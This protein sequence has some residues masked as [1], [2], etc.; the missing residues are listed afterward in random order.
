VQSTLLIAAHPDDEVIGAGARLA[1]FPNLTIAHITDGAPRNMY[2]AARH[3]FQSPA[4]Y[5]K[6]RRNELLR[7][8]AALSADHARTV[9]LGV[10]DQD[11]AY[12]LAELTEAIAGLI[13]DVAPDIILTHPYEGG[14]PDHD[15]CAFAVHAATK[16]R[17]GAPGAGQGT[18]PTLFEFACYHAGA[19]GI[20]TGEF[21]D[22]LGEVT[23]L[24]LSQTELERKD[25][26]LACFETQR[27]TLSLLRSTRECFRPAP[28]YDFTRP[29]HPGK[30]YY[31]QFDWGVTGAAFR[32]LAA[33]AARELDIH[34]EKF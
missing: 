1:A 18:R 9:E 15:A 4:E 2:D 13:R 33:R 30:L 5:A 21:L 16:S 27:E 20:Q 19:N 8:L 14:H 23:T 34:A 6:A 10:P 32:D 17:A 11:A 28:L 26:A 24:D 12:R 31:E 3:G 29:P 22:H 7:A 25:N